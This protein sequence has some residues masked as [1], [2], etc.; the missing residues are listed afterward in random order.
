MH[1]QEPFRTGDG[2]RQL[3]DGQA[4]GIGGDDGFRIRQGAHLPVEIQ[5]DVQIFRNGFHDQVPAPEG[6]Q[7]GGEGDL[8]RRCRGNL[9]FCL[10]Q[11]GLPMVPQRHFIPVLGKDIRHGIAHGPGACNGD[12]LMSMVKSPSI[13]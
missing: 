1:P 8:L 4:G 11:S 10:I 6:V 3:V 9:R 5:F 13:L 12:F 2:F 7:A